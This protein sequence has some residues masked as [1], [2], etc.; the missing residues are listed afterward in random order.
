VEKENVP[1]L[2]GKTKL[3]GIF[4][5]PIGHSLSPLMH[6]TAFAHY[7]LDAVYLPF[8][9]HPAH[10]EIAVKSIAA[11]PIHGVNVTIPHKQAV[12]AWL[13]DVSP[14]A[15]LIG[16]VNTIH[17]RDG[18][19]HG[20]NTDGIGFLRS[21]E[22]A[23]SQVDDRTVILLG[24]GGAARAIAVQLCLSGIRRLYL[25]NRTPT[26]AQELA[27]FLKKN[28]PHADISVVSMGESSLATHLPYTDIVVN[29]TSIGMHAYDPMILPSTELGPRHLVCDIVYRPLHTPLLRAAQRQGARTVDGLGMLLHQGAK[30]FEIWTERAFPIPLIKARLLLAL[31]E[32][33]TAS[34][35]QHKG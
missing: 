6:N 8:A 4:G 30:A 25:A 32:Q 9:V 21:L 33:P 1:S 14:E 7:E 5:Y 24:A 29:A 31:A 35:P 17:L 12:M 11:L 13:D 3:Y 19:L 20:Y 22:E 23:G 34:S 27:A 2:Q 26:R 10:L 16:A 28:I 15:R 18:R